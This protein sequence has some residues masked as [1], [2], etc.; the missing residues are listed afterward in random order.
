MGDTDVRR[1][2]DSHPQFAPVGSGPEGDLRRD[3]GRWSR[4]GSTHVF[5]VTNRR[6][7]TKLKVETVSLVMKWRT[8]SQKNT[9][10][11]HIVKHT[12]ILPMLS[13]KEFLNPLHLLYYHILWAVPVD[14]SLKIDNYNSHT[15]LTKEWKVSC[16]WDGV[17]VKEENVK[18]RKFV[19]NGLIGNVHPQ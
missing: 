16:V 1:P 18:K 5:T 14:V 9:H 17:K 2:N 3:L 12:T 10:T 6:F 7:R 13:E 19:C 11:T 8:Q 4:G 15:T